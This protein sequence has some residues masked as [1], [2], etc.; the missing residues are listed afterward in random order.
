MIDRIM[1]VQHTFSECCGY[2]VVANFICWGN[3]SSK[4]TWNL[5]VYEVWAFK[6]QVLLDRWRKLEKTTDL[7]QVTDKLYHIMLYWLH[8]SW[9]EFE[10]TILVV[11]STDCIGSYNPTTMRSRPRRPLYNVDT[12]RMQKISWKPLVVY[13]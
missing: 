5:I 3:Q 10:L 11:I 8:L 9:A 13:F 6:Y 7:P 1:G 4:R 12:F 2:L